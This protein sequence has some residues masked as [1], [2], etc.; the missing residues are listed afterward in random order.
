M[1]TGT[2]K[3]IPSGRF[4]FL[5]TTNTE[6]ITEDFRQE[7]IRLYLAAKRCLTVAVARRDGR[8][9]AA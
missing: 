7:T 1:G 3:R 4:V 9:N 8:L 2:G 5:P 6:Q